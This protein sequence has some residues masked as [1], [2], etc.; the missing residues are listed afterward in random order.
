MTDR[1]T[2]RGFTLIELLV[3]VL[4]IG[5]L[6]AVAVP[7]Y[8][9]AVQKSRNAQLK[10]LIKTV[11]Q[12]QEA[13]KMANGDYALDFSELDLDLP[14]YTERNEYCAMAGHHSTDSV[15]SDGKFS[16][17]LNN[18]NGDT[19][20]EGIKA[21][22]QKGKY[23]CTGLLYSLSSGQWTCLEGAA[24][25]GAEGSFCKQIEKATSHTANQWGHR[26]YPLN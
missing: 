15:R 19:P 11:A 20:V 3:V 21:V 4:I 2:R 25:V 6:A 17:V 10:T 12:A 24:Y 13:Y 22:W 1:R 5:I 18:S 26:R 23:K 16:I 7:Q 14:S 9:V 8:Q